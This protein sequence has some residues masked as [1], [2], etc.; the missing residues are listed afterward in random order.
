MPSPHPPSYR[1]NPVRWAFG[2]LGFGIKIPDIDR[3]PIRLNYLDIH[4][5]FAT[6]NEL[7]QRISSHYMRQAIREVPSPTL[8]PFR[9]RV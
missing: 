6:S 7:V 8:H 1:E 2:V 5:P 9:L 4:H 3:A